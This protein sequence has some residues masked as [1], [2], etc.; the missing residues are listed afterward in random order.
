MKEKHCSFSKI[1]AN[2]MLTTACCRGHMQGDDVHLL[3]VISSCVS[4]GASSSPS[5][6]HRQS[7]ASTP[8]G[9]SHT[10]PAAAML[11][12]LLTP[13]LTALLSPCQAE[14]GCASA[15]SASSWAMQSSLLLLVGPLAATYPAACLLTWL[16]V[17]SDDAIGCTSACLLVSA[18]LRQFDAIG[19]ASLQQTD[20]LPGLLPRVLHPS[21]ADTF[22]MSS[23]PLAG[24]S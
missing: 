1:T 18:E 23:E 22:P 3:C 11:L 14:D 24:C 10:S 13:S 8:S 2:A 6:S 5:H 9:R 12:G 21:N 15:I 7:S 4:A 20:Q 17:T 16:D 19:C